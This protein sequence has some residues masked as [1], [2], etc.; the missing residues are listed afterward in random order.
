M[1][2]ALVL[3]LRRTMEVSPSNDDAY[4]TI[5]RI[6]DEQIA[7]TVAKLEPLNT[8]EIAVL[9]TG[10]LVAALKLYRE[11]TGALLAEGKVMCDDYI[12]RVSRG[13]II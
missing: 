3:N 8:S 9:L 5:L 6:L 13:S 1:N 12:A 10:N 2:L 7:I 11:R 4:Q